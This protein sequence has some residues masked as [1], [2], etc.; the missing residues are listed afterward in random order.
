MTEYELK[1]LELLSAML[2]KLSSMIIRIW[3][4]LNRTLVIYKVS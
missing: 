1:N 3:V 4:L 2:D